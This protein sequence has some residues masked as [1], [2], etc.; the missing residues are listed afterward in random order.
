MNKKI[1]IAKGER[2]AYYIFLVMLGAIFFGWFM[3]GCGYW[4][5]F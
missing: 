4:G 1:R 3:R 5:G 2:I